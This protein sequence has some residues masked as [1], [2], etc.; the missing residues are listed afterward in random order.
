MGEPARIDRRNFL[1]ASLVGAGLAADVAAQSTAENS[2]TPG[3]WYERAMRWVQIILVEN[4]PGRYDLNF[5]LDLFKR[6]HTT[7]LCLS[8]GG[9]VAYYPTKIPYHHRTPWMKDGGDPFGAFVEGCRKLDM[10]IVA[11]TDAHAMLDDAAK[12]HPEW[13]AV[14]RQ[15]NPRPHWAM[16]GRWLACAYGPY[17]FE[18]MTSVHR[19]LVA[20]YRI[21]GLFVNRWQGN[22]LCYCESCRR[23]FHAFS[24][25]DLP[26][27][28]NLRDPVFA[29]YVEW[30]QSRL[31]ELWKLWD[32]LLQGINPHTRY[33]SN[34]GLE[35]V[36]ASGLS[37]V[38]ISERQTRGANPPW[39]N[40]QGAREV[41]SVFGRKPFFSL[42]SIALSPRDSVATEAE[43]RINLLDGIANGGRPWLMKTSAMAVDRRWVPA[44]EKVYQWHSRN[45][46]YLRN[47]A[48]IARVGLV[49][50]SGMRDLSGVT[51]AAGG[52]RNTGEVRTGPP[53]SYEADPHQSG[54]YHALVEA[55]I[56]FDMVFDRLLDQA[57]LDPYKLLVF[58]NISS[59]SDAQCKQI[60]QYV[61][62]G[63]SILATFETSLYD[64]LGERRPNFGLSELFGVAFNGKVERQV[65]NSYMA[66]ERSTRH[67]ILR[68]MEEFGHIPN[69]G[70]R[71]DVRAVASFPNPPLTRI[72]SYPI[73]PLEE[74][75]PRE[76]N[77]GIPEVFLRQIGS[78]RVVY[79]PGDLE[80]TYWQSMLPDLG[81][82]LRNAVEW[83]VNEEHPVK[84]AG[85]GILD[86]V[87][88][89]QEGS[90]TIHM[91]N[92][93]NPMM[94]RAAFREL[95]PVGEQ[96]V[97][98][99]VPA[100][101]TPHRV[102]RLVDGGTVP[103]AQSGG[104]I[105]FTVPSI[106]DHEVVA[107]DL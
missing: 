83:A 5:W 86:V 9:C 92:L 55:R 10:A 48:S 13:V 87:A 4:D 34:I 24:G 31:V 50:S 41:R 22:G 100:G 95:L 77:T 7:G 104:W 2:A 47:T 26:V 14:D 6:T 21:D 16:P 1:G 75:F 23:Q 58:P 84:V 103:A 44:L 15:G 8:G 69:T 56:P 72:P 59:L 3:E 57:H 89:R 82:L 52:W 68:G 42:A 36:T 63:G 53:P 67:P 49:Y 30:T 20:E 17:N 73:V 37:P 101:Q 90:M 97:S 102:R 70:E 51:G 93:T 76:V 27:G 64:E 99:R 105:T 88:W 78:G 25:K 28:V 43:L 85:P 33:F 60:R 40:G 81:T 106:L 12:A 71:V 65:S 74:L 29:R 98:V 79:F 39:Y 46:K 45:E 107:I 66:I 91:V 18:F 94:L 61:Q 54:M 96:K 35:R 19:E 38:Y 32:G 11:R 62:R 80:R